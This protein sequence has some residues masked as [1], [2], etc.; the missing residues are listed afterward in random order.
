MRILALNNYNS[1][2]GGSEAV[3][4][5]TAAGLRSLGHE[6]TTV[7]AY[8]EADAENSHSHCMGKSGVRRLCFSILD[9]C[10]G[11]F[12]RDIIESFQPDIVHSHIIYGG[13]TYSVVGAIEESGTP[14]VM[15]VHEY[16]L[17]CPV[18]TM[19]NG[20]GEVCEKCATG[21]NVQA[22]VHRCKKSSY[23]WSAH[24]ALDSYVRRY[25]YRNL[26]QINQFIFVSKFA[27]DL[28]LRFRPDIRHKSRL[29]YN[30]SPSDV[31]S[32]SNS[33]ESRS[34]LLYVGRLSAEK[35]LL[36]LIRAMKATGNIALD[37]VGDGPLR[38]ELERAIESMGLVGQV[39]LHGFVERIEI[40]KMMHNR[41][42]LVIPSEWYENNPMSLI[43][44]LSIGLPAIGS[45][46]GGIPE[47]IVN[48]STGKLIEPGN[49]VELQE[50]ISWAKQVG[51]LEWQM[52]SA[53]GRRLV[54]ENF[55]R[56][57]YLQQIVEAYAAAQR[58]S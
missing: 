9:P 23:L 43:E 45:R 40:L 29:I 38:S 20:R 54:R 2:L 27:M 18:F 15:T 57:R 42:F 33:F 49:L 46:I 35:G 41:R 37:I 19:I 56:D 39:R 48:G 30:P 3:F 32:R 4:W 50:A 26:S 7:T 14:H 25:L 31:A 28:H 47:L 52:L 6:V 51:E 8:G 16:K 36:T 58:R 34:G 21:A 55:G 5:D 24:S 12:V 11:R 53:N 10:A 22:I 44:A 17:I 13:L 1:L